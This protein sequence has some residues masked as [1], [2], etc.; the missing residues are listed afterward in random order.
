LLS[1]DAIVDSSSFL[2]DS[3]K[4]AFAHRTGVLDLEYKGEYLCPVLDAFKAEEVITAVDLPL[5]RNFLVA[6]DA[7]L[8][9]ALQPGFHLKK[10]TKNNISIRI[11]ICIYSLIDRLFSTLGRIVLPKSSIFCNNLNRSREVQ[12]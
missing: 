12:C 2:A 4:S 10:M 9:S 6:D 7:T 5:S 1:S 8:L 11:N 3:R